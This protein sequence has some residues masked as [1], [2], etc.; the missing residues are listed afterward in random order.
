MGRVLFDLATQLEDSLPYPVDVEHV[1]AA[2]VL[3]ARQ[4]ELGPDQQLV[5]NDE[6]LIPILIRHLQVIFERYDGRVSEDD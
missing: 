5:A 6:A 1:L 4:G 2:I 3:A